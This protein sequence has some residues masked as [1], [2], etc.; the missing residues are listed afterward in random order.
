MIVAE[1]VALCATWVAWF[2]ANSRVND[3]LTITH[4]G[5]GSITIWKFDSAQMVLLFLEIGATVLVAVAIG[6]WT[7]RQAKQIEGR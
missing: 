2:I 5:G 6:L 3:T 7:T 4:E 1:T